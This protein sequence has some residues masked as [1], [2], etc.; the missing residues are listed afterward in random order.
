MLVA[1]LLFSSIC[2]SQE[3]DTLKNLMSEHLN[4]KGKKPVHSIQVYISK[5]DI[6]FNEAVGYADGKKELAHRNNNLWIFR[7]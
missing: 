3:N 6:I 7:I 5:G 2:Y 4:S 1:T